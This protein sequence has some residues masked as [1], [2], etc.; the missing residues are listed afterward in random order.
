MRFLEILTPGTSLWI[1]RQ[2]FH[3]QGALDVP[4]FASAVRSLQTRHAVL[5]TRLPSI[6]GVA[7]QCCDQ[8]ELELA[9]HDLRDLELLGQD[10]RVC[11]LHAAQ[12]R[13]F[14]LEAG[15]LWRVA[16]AQL[17]DEK[18]VLWLTFH[19][20]VC[21]PWSI[22]IILR[23]LHQLYSANVAGK[24]LELPSLPIQYSD[25]AAWQQD[26]LGS[27]A[28]RSQLDYW[29]AQLR[30]VRAVA[31]PGRRSPNPSRRAGYA[32]FDVPVEVAEGLRTLCTSE[33]VT[34]FVGLLAA[35]QVLLAKYSASDDIA[36]ATAVA[37]RDVPETR[38]VLGLFVNTVVL[39]SDL[40]RVTTFREAVRLAREVVRTGLAHQDVPFEEVINEVRASRGVSMTPIA[41]VMFSLNRLPATPR[42]ADLV[43]QS[44]QDPPTHLAYDLVLHV[45]PRNDRTLMARFDYDVAVIDADLVAEMTR[46]LPQLLALIAKDPERP[47]ATLEFLDARL[48][49][50]PAITDV[51]ISPREDAA[52]S[53]YLAPRTPDEVQLASIWSELLGV[54]PVGIHDRFFSLGGHSLLALRLIARIRA[55]FEVDLP[56]SAVFD[57]LTLADLA[58]QITAVS[59][60]SAAR[61]V[62]GPSGVRRIRLIAPQRGTYLVDRLVPS[63]R[64]NRPMKSIL[65]EGP[66]D[67]RALERA[68][69]ALRVRH[70]ALRTRLFEEDGEL[71]QEML[72]A[73]DLPA[74]HRFDLSSLP[75]EDQARADAEVHERLISRAF[76]L[77]NAEVMVVML[78][79][80][81]PTR[82]RLT[83]ALHR[84]ICDYESLHVFDQELHALWQAFTTDP[85]QTA[86]EL[87][88]LE[89]QF[90]DLADYLGRVG[91]SE[92]GEQQRAYWRA[93]LADAVPLEL[94]T[95]LPRTSVDARRA[96][97]GG[98]V[99]FPIDF[100]GADLD[101]VGSSA[102]E[103]VA[104]EENV[105]VFTVLLAAMSAYL[106]ELTGQRDLSITSHLS[107]RFM[108]GLDRMIGLLANPLIMRLTTA[109][110]Q[111]FRALV[112]RTHEV[113]TS[114][115]D[116]G[117]TD[118]LS[119][120]PHLFR[121]FFNYL[122]VETA[123]VP[124][125][126]SGTTRSVVT[127]P[128]KYEDQIAY[129][130]LL[131]VIHSAGHIHFDLKYN[132]DLFRT[133]GATRL[134][135]GYVDS[136]RRFCAPD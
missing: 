122:R 83:F 87:P 112:A 75:A 65:I 16:I 13:A 6:D 100:V 62:L 119:I 17:A 19:R 86:L 82:H 134:L 73:V 108:P 56:V 49:T 90:L 30:D 22:G 133:D 54:T 63:N 24:S 109:D 126:T 99:T 32:S 105:S 118:I 127:A 21:D 70:G 79:T 80:L 7:S 28:H 5:R 10:D 93:C 36:V 113:V 95:D 44:A 3:L 91:Q 18:W 116:H 104:A 74:V 40:S 35:F 103:R 102:V 34:L 41:N 71:W 66:I 37:N 72:D 131:F 39:R 51:A 26:A 33:N 50:S 129:D 111:P 52:R 117:E 97:H 1:M 101:L 69:L 46:H 128:G 106:T 12:G 68:V 135:N 123:S 76:D 92:L 84:V 110:A 8:T 88:P 27:A 4:A 124:E 115:F 67:V 2:R 15:P 89:I 48:R 114:A 60:K 78:V 94:P 61:P 107:Y 132:L 23:E 42:L 47:L 14:D 31:L 45:T 25:Y 57:T 96:A 29:R 125:P 55:R 43:V 85:E 81:S 59:R 98:Y 77:A 11:S 136:V 130:L 53:G 38:D 121:L 120:A 9:I 64:M 58:A 20:V